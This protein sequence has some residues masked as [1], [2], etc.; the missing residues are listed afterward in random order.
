MFA[1]DWLNTSLSRVKTTEFLL[2]DDV[3]ECTCV[4]GSRV[5]RRNCFSVHDEEPTTMIHVVTLLA[6][7]SNSLPLCTR[8][9]EYDNLN[10]MSQKCRD[11]VTNFTSYNSIKEDTSLSYDEDRVRAFVE[12]NDICACIETYPPTCALR[13]SSSYVSPTICDNFR[14]YIP[15][16]RPP[17]PPRSPPQQLSLPPLPPLPPMSP[18]SPPSPP[19][20]PHPPP[21]PPFSPQ[22]SPPR[23]PHWPP[24]SPPSA[25]R[26]SMGI[27]IVV[28]SAVAVAI[29]ACFIAWKRT[30][31]APT[32]TQVRVEMPR[33]TRTGAPRTS[34]GIPA[35]HI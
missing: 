17:R 12:L 35:R 19:P 21:W 15:P 2:Y 25:L 24:F 30:H 29:L 6:C 33:T 13:V 5:V 26:S 27:I 34:G 8:M 4:R 3:Q 10:S 14:T 7:A 1:R 11:I 20:P 23:P 9:Q 18:P 32:T 28:V 31:S 16:P 22:P